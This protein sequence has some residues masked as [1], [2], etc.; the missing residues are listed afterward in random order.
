MSNHSAPWLKMYTS[1]WRSDPKLRSCSLAARGLWIEM[2]AIMHEAEPYGHLV[3]AGR[4][5]SDKA[6]CALVGATP[7]AT[8]GALAELRAAEVFSVSETGA[9]FSRRMVRDH[10]KSLRDKENGS[11]GGNP[12]LRLRDNPPAN[13]PNNLVA[14]GHDKAQSPESR[15]QKEN[16][17]KDMWDRW[18]K[19][20]RERTTR[21]KVLTALARTPFSV[22]EIHRAMTGYLNSKDAKKDGGEYVRG[23]HTWLRENLDT[24]VDLTKNATPI[25]STPTAQVPDWFS[26]LSVDFANADYVND[27]KTIWSRME[28]CEDGEEVVL[29]SPTS[30]LHVI[31]SS[32]NDLKRF[33]YAV[34]RPV[35]VLPPIFVKPPTRANVP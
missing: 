6:L 9:I 35:R 13:Q 20:G 3:I 1:D 8:A 24:W 19:R 22:E 10:E 23:L 18:P 29:R 2:I 12:T 32:A 14:N 5:V 33:E 11:R 15:V 26:A 27:W 34:G 31:A 28:P 4:P 21:A 17:L 25:P 7:R 30:A 16:V